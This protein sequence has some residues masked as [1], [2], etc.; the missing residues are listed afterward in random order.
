MKTKFLAILFSV[1]IVGI[2]SAQRTTVPEDL[3]ITKVELGTDADNI[4]VLDSE[5]VLKYIPQTTLLD[6]A[7]LQIQPKL[8]LKE[9]LSNKATDFTI[10][11]HTK[12][13][14]VQAVQTELGNYIN[15]SQKAVPNGVAT[16]LSDGKIPLSQISDALLGSV[17]YQGTWN[18]S[19]N[20]PTLI[21]PTDNST[22]GYYYTVSV[23]GAQFGEDYEI[24]DWVISNGANWQ[25][26][27]NNN[28][29]T[30]VF[31]RVGD[32]TA[33]E[34]D[35]SSFFYT[36]TESDTNF[37][38][39]TIGGTVSG[40]LNIENSKFNISGD[41]A[42]S[43]NNQIGSLEMVDVG[44]I[45]SNYTMVAKHDLT[46]GANI[47]L[48][49]DDPTAHIG[50][51]RGGT[52][53]SALAF[54][55]DQTNNGGSIDFRGEN[56]LSSSS[57]GQFTRISQ[58]GDNFEIYNNLNGY[59]NFRNTDIRVGRSTTELAE[60]GS[61]F[62]LEDVTKEWGLDASGFRFTLNGATNTFYFYS[63]VNNT[64]NELFRVKRDSGNFIFS[65]GINIGTNII[66]GN[67]SQLTN[68]EAENLKNEGLT[69]ATLPASPTNG[70]IATIT[71]ANNVVSGG[72]AA[73]GG[74]DTEV[75]VYD[76]T[77]WVY[78]S[79]GGL[80]VNFY[81]EDAFTPTI[82]DSGG[83]ATYSFSS[84]SCN[85]VRTGNSVTVEIEILG[86]NTTGTPNGS[87]R[88]GNLPFNNSR[89]GPVNVA[90]SGSDLSVTE[91]DR[92]IGQVVG[93][94]NFIQL[95]QVN[96]NYQLTTSISSG[97]FY[98]KFTY[99]TNVYTP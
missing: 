25:K 17:N 58:K 72:N 10:I 68:V 49:V 94:G 78:V 22:K 60:S 40:D 47:R 50:F 74:A 93:S 83:G 84:S 63:S 12:Y 81:E 98:S 35:Y 64:I 38:N 90:L 76:G 53:N 6:R 36:K 71:D 62:L 99:I 96:G 88:F 45:R 51:N 5:K 46:Q 23:G 67:G 97:S 21:D 70:D 24:G 79:G 20:T 61:F 4:G 91:L 66:T 15:N 27:D 86:I 89:P 16:L 33:L 29:V 18:A 19:V 42:Q 30:S 1:F 13:P 8:N 28:K 65:R 31:G 56:Y 39:K 44:S 37:L 95:S 48:Q 54:I 73:G 59:T 82:V 80:P 77:N 7:E 26:V 92:L 41:N 52:D 2:A 9:N 32:I 43:S 69:F 57:S 75:V 14:S 55:F 3:Q 87:I 34:G 11:D 85:Y